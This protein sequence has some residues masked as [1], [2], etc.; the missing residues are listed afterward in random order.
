MFSILLL[1]LMEKLYVKTKSGRPI[2]YKTDKERI[3]AKN[4]DKKRWYAA[5]ADTKVVAYNRS[6]YREHKNEPKNDLKNNI[7]NNIP[8][9][10]EINPLPIN[11]IEE[12]K[13]NVPVQ[14][15]SDKLGNIGYFYPKYA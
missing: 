5:N 8:S 11:S 4:L 12:Y 3:E 14:K 7:K 10:Q 2:K 9:E 1:L 15:K 13:K 6:Y